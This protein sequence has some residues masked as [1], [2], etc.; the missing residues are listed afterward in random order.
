MPDQTCA[1]REPCSEECSS[2]R[3]CPMEASGSSMT[4]K[5]CDYI[6]WTRRARIQLRGLIVGSM[7]T[8]NRAYYARPVRN[9]AA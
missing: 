9:S 3:P 2:F 6:G 5:A 1:G 8:D 7:G 4:T